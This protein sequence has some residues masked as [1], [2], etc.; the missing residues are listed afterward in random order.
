MTSKTRSGGDANK[1]TVGE[2]SKNDL[3]SII[4]EC[5]KPVQE[6]VKTLK[7]EVEGLR[8]DVDHYSYQLKL[9]DDKISDLERR[10]EESEQYSRRN[11]LRIFG[12]AEGPKEDTN[13]VVMDVAKKIGACS[14]TVSQI[15]RSH[16]IG[17]PGS[18]PR[19][20]IVKFIGYGPRRA[21]FSAKKALKGSGVTI[22]E[23]LTKQRLDLLKQ[24]AEAYY[25]KNVWTQ[26][27]VIMVKVGDNRPI[28]VRSA[29]DL[30]SLIEKHSPPS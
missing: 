20:I 4:T 15:D 24:A 23:D 12:V 17:K 8:D 11:N 6:T 26:D 7:K 13:Q 25:E 22:R 9:K 18:K 2:M 1:Q 10:I 27:G 19:P 3:I 16:R 21:M 14:I 30:E 29:S 5:L 28:R